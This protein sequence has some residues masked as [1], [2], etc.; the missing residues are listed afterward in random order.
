MRAKSTNL[1]LR[2]R[3]LKLQTTAIVKVV[4]QSVVCRFVYFTI[5]PCSYQHFVK[6]TKSYLVRVK[7][8]AKPPFT[9]W[10]DLG[11][12]KLP[13][14]KVTEGGYLQTVTAR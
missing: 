8:K 13:S 7:G 5:F 11:Y 12:K 1:Y 6:P 2:L 9:F 10:T 3:N 4:S 14:V